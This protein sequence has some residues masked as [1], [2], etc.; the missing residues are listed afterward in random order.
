MELSVQPLSVERLAEAYPLIRSATHVSQ[1]R[2]VEF[3][4]ELLEGAGG[5]LAVTAAD[6]C[7]HGVA[8]YRP[9]RNLRHEQCLDVEVI[10]AFDLR[11][12]D[13]VREALLRELDRIAGDLHCG[14]VNFTVAAKSAEPSSPARSG[15]ERLG[16]KLDTAS[17]VREVPGFAGDD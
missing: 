3:G 5:V 1:E 12:D 15:L 14:A 11:G 10:V 6:K 2:W 7:L 9:S 17:F 13:R 4:R 8:A 16:L